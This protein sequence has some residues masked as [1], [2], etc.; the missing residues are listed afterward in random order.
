[1]LSQDYFPDPNRHIL[2][3]LHL[4]VLAGSHTEHSWRCSKLTLLSKGYGIWDKLW[5]NILGARFERHIGGML[6]SPYCLSLIFILN[7][8][9]QEFWAR[10]WYELGYLLWFILI[11]MVIWLAHQIQN[12]L[13]TSTHVSVHKYLFSRK[14]H[15]FALVYMMDNYKL[16]THIILRNLK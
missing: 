11:L 13:F 3:F 9:H 6:P 8:I 14:K 15:K 16:F 5:E 10:L 2:T 4:M 1:M 7:F 12:A